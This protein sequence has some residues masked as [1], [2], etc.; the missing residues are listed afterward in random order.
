MPITLKAVSPSKGLP[1]E[2]VDLVEESI[3]SMDEKELRAWKRDSAKI[4]A[5]ANAKKVTA[6]V[7]SRSVSASAATAVRGKTR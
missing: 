4:M 2:L 1:K 5:R 6:Y 3:D 7:K